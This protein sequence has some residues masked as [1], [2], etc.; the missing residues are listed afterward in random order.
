[1]RPFLSSCLAICLACLLFPF[2][3]AAESPAPGGNAQA[4]AEMEA[5]FVAANAA[6]QPG[7][8]QLPLA[9]QASLNLPAGFGF[10]PAKEAIR[11]LRAMGNQPGDDILGM[12]VATGEAADWLMVVRYVAAGYVKDEDARDWKADDLLANMREGTEQ[13]NAQRRE[14][15]IPEMEIVGWIEAPQYDAASHR[16]VWSLA[17]RHKGGAA[18]E[19]GVNYNTLM[20]GREGYVSMNLVADRDQI[21]AL[22]PTARLLLAALEFD[23]GK[24]YADFNAS[25]DKVAEYGLAALVAGVAA[26]KLGFFA[27]AAAF[28]L[29]FAKVIG[30]AVI[31]G[32]AGLARW[33]GRKKPA[34]EKDAG[35]A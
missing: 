16:L 33:F 17:S 34:E 7:P 26:K 32:G 9:G 27:L 8:R 35:Q 20:L 30:I 6:L 4:Q 28:L 21:E 12:V 31:A 19:Q 3:A 11:A 18:T 29:K 1:M 5:A 25:T 22:K 15:G 14:R 13:A 24:R 10:I 2:T 23:A